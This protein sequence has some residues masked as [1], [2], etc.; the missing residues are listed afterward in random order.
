MQKIKA[1]LNF[2]LIKVAHYI[3]Q[4]KANKLIENENRP[5]AIY[6]FDDI[7]HLINLEGTYERRELA[8]LKDFLISN[9]MVGGCL[10]NVGANIGN[11]TICLIDLFEQTISFEPNEKTFKLLE[12]NLTPFEGAIAVNKALGSKNESAYME[13]N[14]TNRGASFMTQKP[15][16]AKVET[17][18]LDS[19]SR[20]HDFFST[21]GKHA[22]VIKIDVEGYELNVL[23]GADQFI[24]AYHP[25][26]VFE[27]HL[28]DIFNGTSL[29]INKLKKFRYKNFFSTQTG[30]DKIKNRYLKTVHRA[31]SFLVF[32]DRLKFKKLKY[33]PTAIHPMVVATFNSSNEN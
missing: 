2:F 22:P 23:E 14:K 6:A 26:I 32:G 5:T 12:L 24:R 25:V 27:Q 15:T 28:K 31:F 13:I 20:E 30:E 11:H 29:V 16:A 33:F 21:A 7:G 19:F 3:L 18:T 4:K 1:F 8:A 10:I 9:H 17:I